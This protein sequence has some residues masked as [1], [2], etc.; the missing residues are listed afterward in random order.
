MRNRAYITAIGLDSSASSK[1]KITFE[2]LRPVDYRESD[3]DASASV[4][5][6]VEADSV[7]MAIEKIQTRI[8]RP[9]TLAH[10]SVVLIGE[11]KAK[12][13]DF[14]DIADFFLRHPEVQ[15]RIRLMFVYQ[16]EA[17]ELIATKPL[18]EPILS[19]ELM[20][21]AQLEPQSSFA[22]TNPFIELLRDLRSSGGNG[23]ASRIMVSE[24]DKYLIR[25]GAAVFNQWKLIGW[26]SHIE[27]QAANWIVGDV[28][29]TVEARRGTSIY[30][31]FVNKKRIRV[32]PETSEG[33]VRFKVDLH[34]D[35]TIL[36]QQG[37]RLDLSEPKSIKELE[38]LFAKTIGNQVRGAI[39]KAQ[40]EYQVDYLGFGSALN[41]R[42]PK[43]YRRL[44]WDDIFP[45]IPM[46]VEVKTAITRTGM[47]P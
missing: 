19:G 13:E 35:G 28:D 14:R 22:R 41:R 18:F 23:L 5:Q 26:L 31:Y 25:H 39:A 42:Y 12:T 16:G 43:V 40:N 8:S 38:S 30:T 32:T 37:E 33:N 44:Q 2:I 7:N 45:S 9:I 4:I 17:L 46:E 10:L 24:Q 27:A 34:T 6:T 36:Q 15:K 29:A 47:S 1:Y 20:T 11:E 3:R 21:K